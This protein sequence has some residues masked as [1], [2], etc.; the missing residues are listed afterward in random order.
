MGS[1]SCKYFKRKQDFVGGGDGWKT[2]QL[3][4]FIAQKG[5]R[6]KLAADQ[7]LQN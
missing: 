7:I 2:G 6:F 1:V 4:L 5:E 3:V